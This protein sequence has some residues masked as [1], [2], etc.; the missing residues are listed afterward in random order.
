MQ[1]WLNAEFTVFD[2]VTNIC[3]NCLL[4]VK[5]AIRE[6]EFYEYMDQ[7]IRISDERINDERVS[8]GWTSDE[9][10][11]VERIGKERKLAMNELSDEN[12]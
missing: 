7:L 1:L 6:Y 10:I 2:E 12:Q 3:I 4:W 11:S 8:D 5:L 9:R